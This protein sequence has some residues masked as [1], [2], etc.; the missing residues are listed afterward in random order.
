M[1][2]WNALP[3]F[4]CYLVD[5]AQKDI[6][7]IKN[8]NGTTIYPK[9]TGEAITVKKDTSGNTEILDTF[10]NN[11]HS[12]LE[13]DII[14]QVDGTYS[15]GSSTKAFKEAYIDKL[16]AE[17]LYGL[18]PV[19]AVY[20]TLGD[21]YP[22][23]LFGGTWVKIKGAFLLGSSD[24]YSVK[25]SSETELNAIDGGEA[26]HKLTIAEMPKHS[27][28]ITTYG[29]LTTGG[30]SWTARWTGTS[31]GATE[32]TGGDEAHNNMPPYKVVNIWRRQA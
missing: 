12:A 6:V 22:D 5:M 27:H 7:E 24:T 14:P 17:K 11:L 16:N 21:E 25:N 18:Y 26:T 31:E 10:L 29:S 1:T 28:S 30:S 4:R 19:G 2:E 3:S 32:E 8:Q 9:T 13:F 20:I 15:L 23:D